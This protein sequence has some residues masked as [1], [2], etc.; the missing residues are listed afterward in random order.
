M[1]LAKRHWILLLVPAALIVGISLFSNHIVPLYDGVGFPDEPYR[2]VNPP[3]A[4]KKT[5]PPSP[6]ETNVVL[7]HSTNPNDFSFAS[8]EQGPQVNIYVYRL[9]LQSS[10]AVPKITFKAE[11]K[12]PGNTKTPK[13]KIAGNYYRFGA[14]GEGG[15]ASFKTTEGIGYLYLRLPQRFPAGASVIYRTSAK[16]KW[17]PLTTQRTG[18]DIYEAKLKGFGDYALVQSKDSSSKPSLPFFV[19]YVL[20]FMLALLVAALLFVR[21]RLHKPKHRK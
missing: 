8:R 12:D 7:S 3:T 11:P 21:F 17:Q 5:L 9:S 4:A 13:G 20:L 2:Y 10:A 1:S 16:D 19:I 18:N 14:I 15:T 6:A